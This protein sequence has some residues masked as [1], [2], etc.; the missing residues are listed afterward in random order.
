MKSECYSM[1]SLSRYTHQ[2]RSY[3]AIMQF[4]ANFGH[5][6]NGV[7][8]NITTF[9]QLK[10]LQSILNGTKMVDFKINWNA[11]EKRT[12]WK[13]A[14]CKFGSN[15]CFNGLICSSPCRLNTWPNEFF[16][17]IRPSQRFFKCAF[18]SISSFGTALVACPSVSA[19]SS[20]S[21]QND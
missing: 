18:F 20:K 16:V 17:K 19:T 21:L 13:S 10:E 3:A 5:F 8:L 4:I 15:F 12:F 6:N 1:R 7:G 9:L 2:C 11:E 14:S